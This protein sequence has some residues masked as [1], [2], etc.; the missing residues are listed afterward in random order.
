MSHEYQLHSIV[1]FIFKMINWF[2]LENQFISSSLF[3]S[4]FLPC[5]SKLLN[6]YDI[7]LDEALLKSL[8]VKLQIRENL[9]YLTQLYIAET[10][11]YIYLEK[12]KQ[13]DLAKLVIA[14]NLAEFGI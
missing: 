6:K 9:H 10:S 2:S 1:K 5:L 12:M 11:F 14:A 8:L 4:L 13:E 7:T 3:E